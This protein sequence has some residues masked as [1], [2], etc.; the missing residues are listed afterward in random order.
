MRYTKG[1]ILGR[2]AVV[3]AFKTAK[4]VSAPNDGYYALEVLEATE[5]EILEKGE[6]VVR[7]EE[8][9][10]IFYEKVDLF[11]KVGQTY[12]YKKSSWRDSAVRFVVL[13][14]YVLDTPLYSDLK[15]S[16]VAKMVDVDGEEGMVILDRADFKNMEKV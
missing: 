13:E 6:I 12:S 14:T 7:S 1:D 2:K 4:V 11:Y 15:D 10:D 9:I 8:V 16:A 3:G 5:D